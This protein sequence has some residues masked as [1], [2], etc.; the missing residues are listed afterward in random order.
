MIEE[1]RCTKCSQ[2]LEYDD[3]VWCKVCSKEVFVVKE[4]CSKHDKLFTNENK[5][6]YCYEETNN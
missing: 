5:C 4:Y 6:P 1:T 2:P 3:T